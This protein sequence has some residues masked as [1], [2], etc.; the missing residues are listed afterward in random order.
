[1]C[2][3]GLTLTLKRT[4]PIGPVAEN[5]TRPDLNITRPDLPT[6]SYFYYKHDKCV[7]D[8]VP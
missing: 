5:F 4:R 3:Q 7:H 6:Y 2:H 1:M 8:S